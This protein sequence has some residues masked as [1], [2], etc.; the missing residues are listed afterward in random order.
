MIE[1]TIQTRLFGGEERCD[2]ASIFCSSL[3]SEEINVLYQV[4]DGFVMDR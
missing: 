2:K 1:S 3:R 4:Y